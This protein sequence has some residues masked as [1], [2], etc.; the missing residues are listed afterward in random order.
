MCKAT[1][2]SL[3]HH[4]GATHC[5]QMSG[6]SGSIPVTAS[7]YGKRDREAKADVVIPVTPFTKI[8]VTKLFGPNRATI[9]HSSCG[10]C[11]HI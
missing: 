10:S 11:P 9:L 6:F 2:I 7:D 1:P 5:L 3:G 8:I 4:V